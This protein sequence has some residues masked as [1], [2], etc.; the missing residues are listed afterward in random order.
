MNKF[1][2]I[3][4]LYIISFIHSAQAIELNGNLS[5]DFEYTNNATLVS[6]QKDDDIS[7]LV[8]LDFTVLENRKSVQANANFRIENEQYYNNSFSDRTSLTAGFGGL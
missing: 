8:G 7:Q 3:L 1:T 5:T 4:A 6:T 2:S